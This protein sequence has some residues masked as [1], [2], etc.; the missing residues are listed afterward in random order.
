MKI[1]RFDKTLARLVKTTEKV[2]RMTIGD[3][4]YITDHYVLVRLEPEHVKT[5]YELEGRGVGQN[6]G[7]RPSGLDGEDSIIPTPENYIESARVLL[8][9][10]GG[11]RL[12]DT[13]IQTCRGHHDIRLYRTKTDLVGIATEYQAIVEGYPSE[14][15][16]FKEQNLACFQWVQGGIYEI[17]IMR[18]RSKELETQIKELAQIA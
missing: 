14:P 2:Y 16:Y 1:D 8:S 12:I 9:L 7:V 18:C 6:Q 5:I 15:R 11:E 13:E 4:E 10:V 3:R 17:Y